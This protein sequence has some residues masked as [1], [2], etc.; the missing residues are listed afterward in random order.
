M[1]CLL[2]GN[3]YTFIKNFFIVLALSKYKKTLC[4]SVT[5]IIR[6]YIVLYMFS[7]CLLS[8]MFASG[9]LSFLSTVLSLSLGRVPSAER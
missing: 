1:E 2:I 9:T 5:Q 7:K 6:V 8:T 4:S 3:I